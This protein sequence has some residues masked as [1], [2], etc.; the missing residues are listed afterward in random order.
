MKNYREPRA[1]LALPNQEAY[2]TLRTAFQRIGVDAYRASDIDSIP[3]MALRMDSLAIVMD[4]SGWAHEAIVTA[5]KAIRSNPESRDVLLAVWV[6][7]NDQTHEAFAA[8]GANVVMTHPITFAASLKLIW[9]LSRRPWITEKQAGDMQGEAPDPTDV[10]RERILKRQ[11]RH[12]IFIGAAPGV[13]K[14]YA[15]LSQ[16]HELLSRGEDVVIGVVETHGRKETERLVARLPM[17]PK[18]EVDYKGTHQYEMDLDAILKRHPST[19]LV[20]ELAHSN[21]PGSLNSKRYEDVQLMRMAGTSVIS[22]LN[23]Q[24][25]ESLNNIIE[26]LTGVKVRETVPDTVLEEADELVLSDIS[27]QALQQRLKEGKI[28]GQEKVDQALSNFFSTHNLTALRELV[29][30]ELADRVEVSLD[31]VRADIGKAEQPTGIQDRILICITASIHAQR[32]IRRG[33]RLA[34]RLG[35]DRIVIYVGDAPLNA[36]Q[37]ATLAQNIGLAESLEAEVVKL[38]AI[39]AASA[40]ARFASEHQITMIMLGE[41]RRTRL[42]ALVRKPILDVLLEK[43]T[44]IDVVIVASNE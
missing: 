16:A 40:I 30:R 35:A 10:L 18:T 34:D 44:N 32:L 4:A 36:E 6:E 7:A 15:M 11:A 39:D 2:D 28:Y 3:K 31:L 25:L 24:H 21:L 8:A 33:T 26:R 43:T 14:T 5:L 38:Q 9:R 23:V 29:L 27:P 41:T 13:G 1:I 19:V 42:N 12:K 37:A 17:I 22:T 20:D